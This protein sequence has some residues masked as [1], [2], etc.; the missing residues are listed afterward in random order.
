MQPATDNQ[1]IAAVPTLEDIAH[2]PAL[3]LGLPE[4]LKDKLVARCAALIVTLTLPASEPVQTREAPAG[5]AEPSERLLTAGET[6]GM[7]GCATSY[8]YELLRKGAIPA[9]R[10]GK[11]VRIR[12]STLVELIERNERAGL[13]SAPLSIML[14]GRNDER[15]GTEAL[16]RK[17]GAQPGTARRK[18]GCASD[19]GQPMGARDGSGA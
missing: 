9:I 18:S 6:A 1:R 2:N 17:A 19:D 13:D 10:L 3:A 5:Q 12:Y 15:K 7:L 4:S 14:S 16:P 8:V 11:Y